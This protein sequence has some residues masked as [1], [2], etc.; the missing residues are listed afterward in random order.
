MATLA[1]GLFP[2]WDSFFIVDFVEI[3]VIHHVNPISR[4]SHKIRASERPQRPRAANG[5]PGEE[6]DGTGE[7]ETWRR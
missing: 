3:F 6:T 1:S 7:K 5:G 2:E 4:L